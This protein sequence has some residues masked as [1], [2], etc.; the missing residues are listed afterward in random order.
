MTVICVIQAR[1]AS[2]R[3]PGKV[4]EPIGDR[5]MLAM[6]IHRAS[7]AASVE[8]TI[9][10]T[11]TETSDDTVAAA[12]AEAGARVVR[13]SQFD[14]LDRF[15]AALSMEP[16]ADILVRLT[17]DCPFVDPDVIDLV[18]NNL[19]DGNLDFSANR[20]PPPHPRTYPVGLDVEA[21]KTKALRTAWREATFPHQREHVMP[22]IYENPRD[23]RFGVVDL[24]VDLSSFRW[25]VDTADDLAAVRRIAALVGP[26]PFGWRDV[27]SVAQAHPEIGDLNRSARQKAVTEH[28]SRWDAHDDVVS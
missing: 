3:L 4:L 12:A 9:V 27:L 24:D 16:S 1:F 23:F 5:S 7:R 13:G 6:V 14:V 22:Y 18:V 25:T 19:I 15:Y 17:A 11:S 8:H 10:A 26:E 2:S 21:C 28:D 20:L